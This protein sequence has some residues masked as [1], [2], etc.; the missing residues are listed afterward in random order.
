MRGQLALTGILLVLIAAA[1]AYT[2]EEPR[3]PV[4]AAGMEEPRDG[5]VRLESLSLE[6]EIGLM[7][8]TYP[9]RS[10]LRSPSVLGDIHL[11]AEPNASMYRERIGRHE[12][13]AP[14]D[15]L[16]SIDLEKCFNPLERFQRFPAADNV[17]TAAQAGTL[18]RHHGAALADLGVDINFAPVIDLN[19]TIWQ[20]RTFT[21]TPEAV[22]AKGCAYIEGLQSEGVIATAKHYPGRTLTG[23]D[24]H[25][26]QKSV[27]IR[28]RDILPFRRAVAC[29]VSAVMVSHQA[30]TGAVASNGRP[31]TVSPAVIDR[32]REEFDGLVVADAITMGGLDDHYE[33]DREKY[34]DLVRAGNDLLLH[35]PTEPGEK[36]G[37]VDAIAAAVRRGEL[38]RETIDRSATRLLN[39]RRL[40][41][42]VRTPN[43]TRVEPGWNI[44]GRG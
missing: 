27:E 29:N 19:D 38:P 11:T 12:A 8:G 44:T 5:T 18:G 30:A 2:P 9:L 7:V 34:V 26:K 41:V 23:K 1:P 40:D 36:R 15:P 4:S 13:A 20:C 17:T 25:K 24:P 14:I 6:Q 43:G 10:S 37:M 35:L 3:W 32:L 22:A 39:A 33:E 31:A 16:Y 42:I 21:G 28:E